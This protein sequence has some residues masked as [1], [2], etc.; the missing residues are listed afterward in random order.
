[1]RAA[2][3]TNILTP[4]RV[5]MYKALTAAT[6]IQ[7][8]VFTNASTEFDR[9]WQ[10]D[11][12]DLEVEAVRSIRFLRRFAV[13]SRG[14]R[15]CEQNVTTYIPI[16][17]IGSLRRFRP[18]VVVS[19]ELG[20]RTL[21]ALAYCWLHRIPLVI[22]SYHS[23]ASAAATPGMQPGNSGVWEEL[24]HRLRRWMLSNASAVVGMG[25][26]ARTV[27]NE[28]GVEDERIFDAPNAHDNVGFAAALAVAPKACLRD[29]LAERG[30]REQIA[31]VVGRLIPAKGIVPL[32]DVWDR[33]PPPVR[34]KWSLLF[35][36]DGP[37]ARDL[38]RASET[39]ERGEILR[40]P[41]VQPAELIDYYR[42]A[43]ML[44]FPSLGDPWGLVVNE[45]LACG[46][47]VMCSRH[48]GCADDI[49]VPGHNGW[50]IDPNDPEQMLETLLEAMAHPDIDSFHQRAKQTAARFSSQAM[51][52]GIVAAVRSALD[53]RFERR[54]P[55]SPSRYA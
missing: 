10:I 52:D 33:L 24:A 44:V 35:V 49:V 17:L 38:E 55:V 28:L 26:Q 4:Y 18:D 43:K 13:G 19:A 48:A 12:G 11:A 20:M 31:L 8:R 30:C 25:R 27:L 1:M 34:A 37:L 7:W 15:S 41:A 29:E 2:L 3:L 36:G 5:P 23:L 51:A 42:A 54:N 14:Q 32:L 6:G 45:A 22:W 21:I 53:S 46:L 47:P 40:D 16:G 50:I 9:S 39:H